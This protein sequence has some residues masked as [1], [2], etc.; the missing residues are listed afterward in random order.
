LIL[1]NPDTR[2]DKDEETIVQDE[3]QSLGEEEQSPKVEFLFDRIKNGAYLDFIQALDQYNI[4]PST[5]IDKHG[6]SPLHWAAGCGNLELVTY[7]ITKGKCDPNQGQRG[8]RSYGGRTPIH[9]A[10]RNG[11]LHIIQYLVETSCVDIDAETMDG[12]T[13]FCWAAWQGHLHIMKY[14]AAHNCNVGKVNKYSC[15]AVLWAAQSQ[16]PDTLLCLQWLDS[17]GCDIRLINSNGHGILHKAAQRGRRNICEWVIGKG[18][19]INLMEQI[20]PDMGDHC[21]SDL[22]GMEG[23]YELAQWLSHM[24]CKIAE[25]VFQTNDLKWLSKG[26]SDA[27]SVAQ[28]IGIWDTWE[29]LG[30]IRRISAHLVH[31]GTRS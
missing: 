12:T 24:E 9:W 16:S 25:E 23:H 18:N 10:A 20:S 2:I 11:H 13:A 4:E 19:S 7:L 8:I 3:I 6:A 5:L 1:R 14:L 21:P 31:R 15:N 28:T 29:P 26:M 27:H 30:G 22:A 17:F